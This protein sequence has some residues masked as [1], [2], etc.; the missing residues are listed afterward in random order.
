M[1]IKI[2]FLFLTSHYIQTLFLIDDIIIRGDSSDT[3]RRAISHWIMASNSS[4]LWVS[5]SHFDLIRITASNFLINTMS[6]TDLEIRRNLSILSNLANNFLHTVINSFL[7][8]SSSL[9]LSIWDLLATWSLAL[10][11]FTFTL[12]TH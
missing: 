9:N 1:H 8:L 3:S 7:Y 11:A 4:S 5:Q 6:F 2:R 12:L 10:R